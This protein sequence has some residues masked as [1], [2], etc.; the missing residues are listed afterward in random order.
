MAQVP[1]VNENGERVPVWKRH[2]LAKKLAERARTE[3]SERR[4]VSGLSKSI[5]ELYLLAVI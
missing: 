5:I 4:A 3:D 2:E 1:Q